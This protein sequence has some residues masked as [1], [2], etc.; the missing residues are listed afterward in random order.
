MPYVDIDGTGLHTPA[1]TY[2]GRAAVVLVQI[3]FELVHEALAHPLRFKAAGIVA[4]TVKREQREHAR[5]PQPQPL[6]FIRAYFVL[7]V[8]T[9]TGG[10]QERAGAAVD[11]CELDILPDRR[12][13]KLDHLHLRKGGRV[14]SMPDPLL[15]CCLFLES[16]G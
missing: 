12:F 14:E 7:N 16:Q 9:P 5:I 10:T 13:K 1:A 3:I 11:A 8:E 2:A 15:R 6:A 4:G